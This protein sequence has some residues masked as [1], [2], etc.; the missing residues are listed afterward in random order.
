M[1]YVANW[2]DRTSVV[3][4]ILNNTIEMWSNNILP[5][6]NNNNN[7]KNVTYTQLNHECTSNMVRQTH[8]H[9][10]CLNL[11]IDTR[12]GGLLNERRNY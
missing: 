7:I 1:V 11:L 12:A 4:D 3:N 2:I 5:K 8:T 6:I 9:T 10:H